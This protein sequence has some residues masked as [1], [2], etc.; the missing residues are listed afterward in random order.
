LFAANSSEGILVQY[1]RNR[2]HQI[3]LNQIE[4]IKNRG[5]RWLPR[6]RI[7]GDAKIEDLHGQSRVKWIGYEDPIW[8]LMETLQHCS[9]KLNDFSDRQEQE[10]P[11]TELPLALDEAFWL[12]I[13]V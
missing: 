6:L 12:L 5:I 3:D 9:D 2:L 10:N 4:T 7:Q 11:S 8:H 13:H 1:K